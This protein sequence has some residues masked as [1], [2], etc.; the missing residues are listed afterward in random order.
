MMNAGVPSW[1]FWIRGRSYYKVLVS[2]IV[3]ILRMDIELP[4]TLAV[5]MRSD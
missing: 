1:M 2:A 5:M 3:A 4:V